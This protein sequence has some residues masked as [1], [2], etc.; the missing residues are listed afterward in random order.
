VGMEVKT[1]RHGEEAWEILQ[2]ETVNLVVTDLSMPVMNGIE[3]A[4]RVRE[5]FPNLPIV[6]MTGWG[7]FIPHQEIQEL[8]IFTV[9]QKPIAM[10]T[11]RDTFS[12]LVEQISMPH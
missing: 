8:G 5:K 2:G 3:L 6:L 7:D 10:Q 11:W 1:A 9:L 12:T 4:K